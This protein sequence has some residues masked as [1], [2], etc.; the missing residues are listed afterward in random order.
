MTAI[1]TAMDKVVIP[2]VELAVRSIT[3]SSGRRPS[4]VVQNPDRRDF[5]GNSENTPLMSASSR[6]DLNVD[7][8]KN[9]ETRIVESFKDGDFPAL[10]PKYDRRAHA[11]HKEGKHVPKSGLKTNLL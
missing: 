11:Q 4:N 1:L 7:Q 9:D 6:M 2:R 3:E 10:G 5:T 8:D